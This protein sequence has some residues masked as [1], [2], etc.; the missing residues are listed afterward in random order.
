MYRAGD[1]ANKI[2]LSGDVT[3]TG[4]VNFAGGTTA[5]GSNAFDQIVVNQTSTLT[6]DVACGAALTVTGA[7]T[8]AA[9]DGQR[10]SA[11]S[12]LR[13]HGGRQCRE[14]HGHG[15]RQCR[16]CRLRPFAIPKRR[17]DQCPQ[18]LG[19]GRRARFGPGRPRGCCTFLSTHST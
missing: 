11:G 7:T 18:G 8:L 19:A 3:V 16:V 4:Q 2:Q 9:V 15:R 13:D 6:G 12:Q 14:R 5:T 1:G 17:A 10:D